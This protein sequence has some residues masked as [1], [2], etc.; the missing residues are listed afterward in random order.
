MTN[1]VI[2]VHVLKKMREEKGLLQK[3]VA[4][5]LGV[6]RTAYV[7][8]EK[9]YSE[10]NFQTLEKLADFFG[11]SIDCILG[12]R[13]FPDTPLSTGGVWIPVLGK[14][15]AG[16]PIEAIEYIEDYEEIPLDMASQG[17]YFALKVQGDSMEPKI[18]NG[19]VVIVASRPTLIR[20]RLQLCLSTAMRRRL[21]A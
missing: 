5:A 1:G 17:D 16:V 15:A 7:K 18:S 3:D 12:R 4:A 20:A 8:Y 2:L 9:G 11:V 21:S 13:V 14:V 10:P 6:D 19:D